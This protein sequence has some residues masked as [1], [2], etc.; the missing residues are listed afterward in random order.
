M[1]PDHELRQV[2][3]GEARG[4]KN[5][6]R[7]L[8]SHFWP[9]ALPRGPKSYYVVEVVFHHFTFLAAKQPKK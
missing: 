5:K 4:K 1:D 6:H 3:N 9:R 8:G 7:Y 2:V